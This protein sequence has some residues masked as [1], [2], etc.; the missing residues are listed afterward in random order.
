[1]EEIWKEVK[2]FE[3]YYEVSN[4]GRVRSIDRYVPHVNGSERLIRGRLMKLQN[5]DFGYKQIT[6]VEDKKTKTYK[7]HRLVAEAFIPNPHN[8]QCVTHKD[9]NVTNN[10]VENLMWCTYEHYLDRD[11]NREKAIKTVSRTVLQ[12]TKDGKFVNEYPSMIEAE[13]QTGIFSVQISKCCKGIKHH[14]S[15]GGFIWRFKD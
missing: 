6:L 13:R 9:G 7:V 3:D 4:M 1:M 5:S 8:Y 2:Y 14:R 15:A 12:Y 10:N 11:K